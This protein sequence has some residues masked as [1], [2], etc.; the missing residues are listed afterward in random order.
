[1]QPNGPIVTFKI[2]QAA[3]NPQLENSLWGRKWGDLLWLC[4]QRAGLG[5]EGYCLGEH[6]H[7]PQE[8]GQEGSRRGS[9]HWQSAQQP[10]GCT[11]SGVSE[12]YL[13]GTKSLESDRQLGCKSQLHPSPGLSL[14]IP[15]NKVGSLLESYSG[16]CA[17]LRPTHSKPLR[18]AG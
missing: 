18:K 9:S 12:A 17:W 10:G 8:G 5:S 4:L 1:M 15:I 14:N 6:A 11:L 2:A 7:R 16:D 3:G 13:L